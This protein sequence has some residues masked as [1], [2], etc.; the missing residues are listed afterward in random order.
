MR[1]ITLAA[2]TVACIAPAL[3]GQTCKYVDADGRITF[4]NV[5]VKNARKVMCFEPV[6]HA[7]PKRLG[8]A[9]GSSAQPPGQDRETVRID[10][11]TQQRRDLDRRQILER[12]LAEER[13]LLE[14]ARRTLSQSTSTSGRERESPDPAL[15]AVQ[16]HQRNVEAI[17]RELSAIR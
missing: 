12:E 5:P 6:P 1:F 2:L 13:R 11:A 3:A 14:A 15:E 17:E 10:P 9:P 7:A 16:R 4:A 8:H